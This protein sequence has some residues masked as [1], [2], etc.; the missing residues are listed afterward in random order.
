MDR[1]PVFDYNTLFARL[2]EN[3]EIAA[4][5]FEVQTCVLSTLS[6]EDFFDVLLGTMREK[7]EVPFCWLSI[8]S[9]GRAARLI[10]RFTPHEPVNY[11]SRKHFQQIVGESHRPLL[12]NKEMH[13]LRN[14]QPEGLH[15]E[16]RSIAITPISLDGRIIGSFNQADPS[17]RR[18]Q[19][20][21]D[22]SLLEQLGMVVSICLSNVAAHEELREMA[23]KDPLTG[24][25]NRRAMERILRRE[26]E[27][28][29]RYGQ[30]LSLVFIDLDDFKQVNDCFGHDRGDDLLVHVAS[31]LMEMSRETDVIA[32]Y[33]GDEFVMILPG[34]EKREAEAYM[35]R[36]KAHFKEHPLHTHGTALP[37]KFSFGVASLKDRDVTNA[38]SLLK[39]AD[40]ALYVAKEHK[41]D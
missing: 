32:R 4:K 19:P 13:K 10:E 21:I 37:I 29:R 2:K 40:E 41:N 36:I 8:I 30:P 31:H 15:Y 35:E 22:T 34:I 9:P 38:P 16:F 1:D 6:F 11:I 7:F 5:F 17:L 33:A 25:L 12:L 27:R 24:L 14:L 39:K 3:E 28:D 20:G 18:F 26:V 23:F